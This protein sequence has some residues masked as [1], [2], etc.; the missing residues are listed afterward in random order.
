MTVY[1]AE[2]DPQ[3]ETINE[4]YLCDCASH[5]HTFK[6]FAD[7]EYQEVFIS[8][9]LSTYFTFWQRLLHGVKYIFGYKSRYGSYD[10]II[11]KKEDVIKMRDALSGW[12]EKDGD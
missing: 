4:I 1:K 10:S 12:L 3:H 9:Y 5:E 8:P 7:N 6:L 11:L 2:I